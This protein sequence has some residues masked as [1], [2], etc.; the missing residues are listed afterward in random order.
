MKIRQVAWIAVLLAAALLCGCADAQ[1]TPAASGTPTP[2]ST[3]AP[4]PAVTP[5]VTP[6]PTTPPEE[7]TPEPVMIAV[8][9]GDTLERDIIPQLT[10]ALGITEQQAKDAL[11]QAQS[12]LIGSDAE[13]FRRMEGIIPPGDYNVAG[14]SLEECVLI[15]V[16]AA[17][18]RYAR[19]AGAVTDENAL[20]AAERLTLASIVEWETVL[21]DAYEADAAAA[22]LNR[23][24][25]GGK[26]Q[27]CA[28]VEYALGYQQ[29]Y[30]TGDDI[31]V[32]SAYNTYR[33]RGLPPGPICALDDECLEAASAK[34]NNPDTYFFFY[35][36][37]LRQVL[38]FSTYEDFKAAA[39]AS[40]ERFEAAFDIGRND[41]VDKREYFGG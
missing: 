3:P 25:D 32:D 31:E 2:V 15:W 12:V 9:D 34:A 8:R 6:V 37:A 18:A 26:L 30:L 33:V 35:D 10:A 1:L 39:P 4:T 23:L 36:Y 5:A 7:A 24:D 38:S 27:S 11:A 21:A 28:T 41:K 40:K 16:E 20:S 19:V 13:G 22:F 14:L 29:P 17:E